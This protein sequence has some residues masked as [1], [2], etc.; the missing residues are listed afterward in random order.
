MTH[1]EFHGLKLNDNA[2]SQTQ[3]LKM[4]TISRHQL[5][6]LHQGYRQQE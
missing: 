3:L 4:A 5:P 2:F 1:G 6:N